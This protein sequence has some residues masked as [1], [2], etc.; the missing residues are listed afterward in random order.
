MNNNEATI[1]KMKELRLQGM[2]VADL[3]NLETGLNEKYTPD[4]LVTH[5]IDS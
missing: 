1:S 2:A 5:L 3:N 4:E